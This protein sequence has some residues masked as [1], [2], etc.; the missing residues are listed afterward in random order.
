MKRERAGRGSER[1][2]EEGEEERGGYE[3]MRI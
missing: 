3:D 1:Q 2:R